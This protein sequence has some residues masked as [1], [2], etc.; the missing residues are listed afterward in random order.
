MLQAA[1]GS[2]LATITVA[3]T[4]SGSMVAY[5]DLPEPRLRCA[6]AGAVLEFVGTVLV[7]VGA[8]DFGLGVA[9]LGLLIVLWAWLHRTRGLPL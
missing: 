7:F 4:E 8:G 5:I 9:S 1:Q 3:C 6:V 2:P